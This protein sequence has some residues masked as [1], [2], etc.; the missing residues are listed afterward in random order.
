VSGLPE[1]GKHLSDQRSCVTPCR[2][3]VHRNAAR[4]S[5]RCSEPKQPQTRSA[6]ARAPCAEEGRGPRGQ[7]G[8]ACKPRHLTASLKRWSFARPDPGSCS[9]QRREVSSLTGTKRVRSFEVGVH[10]SQDTEPCSR[11]LA[12]DALLARSPRANLEPGSL[13]PRRWR[14]FVDE[15]GAY[16]DGSEFCVGGVLLEAGS[17]RAARLWA[18]VLRARE[19]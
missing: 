19:A 9:E 15:S 10:G 3:C 4:H 6:F 11:I 13:M 2:F 17:G 7:V 14:L 1:E 8:W 12:T 18:L 5:K 16:T